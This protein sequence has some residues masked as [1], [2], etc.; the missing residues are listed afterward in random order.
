MDD[1]KT[2][3]QKLREEQNEG[4]FN[5]PAFTK[6]IDKYFEMKKN[7]S[8]NTSC[9][10]YYD[11]EQSKKIYYPKPIKGILLGSGYMISAFDPSFRP[12]GGSFKSSV[13]LHRSHIFPL[14]HPSTRG[15]IFT[16]NKEDCVNFISTKT[17]DSIK[18]HQVIWILSET[19]SVYQI[20]TNVSIFISNT[21][22]EKL[23]ALDYCLFNPAMYDPNDTK[24]TPKTHSV[25]G[26]LAKS[27]KPAYVYVSKLDQEISEEMAEKLELFAVVEEFDEFKKHK[28]NYSAFDN[29]TPPEP[30]R[31]SEPISNNYDEPE[32]IEPTDDLPF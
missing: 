12:N 2:R 20:T 1:Y 15:A 14:Y 4:N 11:K 5:T 31:K 19:G 8:D 24:I 17:R 25:L 3:L 13:F 28:K 10:V 9:F 6:R 26:G 16:G 7:P 30:V 27:N 32:G 22:T 21:E 18:T 29:D 23:H